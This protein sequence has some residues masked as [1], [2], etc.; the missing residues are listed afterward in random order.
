MSLLANSDEE[1]VNLIA[2]CVIKDQ[3]AFELLYQKTSAYL[4]YVAFRIVK[5]EEL[6]NEVLQEAYI[7]IWRNAHQYRQ[8]L[9]KPI[10][11]LTS[12][13]RYRAL[14]RVELEKRHGRFS[15]GDDDIAVEEIEDIRG[16]LSHFESEEKVKHILDCLQGLN[17]KVKK[18][19]ELAYLHGYSREELAEK[20][21]SNVNTIKSWLHRGSEKLRKCLDL[22]SEAPSC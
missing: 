15:Y 17:E 11:W 13:V 1:L 4:N 22:K 7:Q 20:L 18:S 10:T 5:N 2:R 6:S 21:D 9:A 14:D 12:I 19:L 16:P 3:K 8:N